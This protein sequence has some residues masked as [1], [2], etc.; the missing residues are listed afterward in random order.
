M[1]ATTLDGGGGEEDK[2]K[3]RVFKYLFKLTLDIS[4]LIIKKKIT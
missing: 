1:V 2:D 3:I 4:R